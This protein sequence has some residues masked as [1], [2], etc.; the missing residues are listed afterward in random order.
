[1][2]PLWHL[3][4]AILAAMAVG[5]HKKHG[6][7][8]IVLLAFI[9]MLIDVDHLF[10]AYPRALHNIFITVALPLSLFYVAFHYEKRTGSIKFQ[11]YALIMFIILVSHVISDMFYGNSIA[12]LYPLSTAA[13][14]L[15]QISYS[16]FGYKLI[17]PEGIALT[18][19]VLI[20]AL[21]YFVEDFIFWFEKKHKSR[22]A[23]IRR[24][25]EEFF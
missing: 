22:K 20:V 21:V 19:F 10:F 25:E 3:V 11:S 13:V 18:V 12:F 7:R 14:S 17:S 5:L 23:A 15:P 1:M 16:L 6:M 24:V 8:D 2:D 9:A 4:F